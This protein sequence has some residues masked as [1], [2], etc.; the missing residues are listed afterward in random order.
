MV[1][2]KSFLDVFFTFNWL[3]SRSHRFAEMYLKNCLKGAK[4]KMDCSLSRLFSSIWQ[5]KKWGWSAKLEVI[6]VVD[7][8][9]VSHFSCSLSFV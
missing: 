8:V 3:A 1:T 6:L 5:E 4:A 7:D 9:K 2:N